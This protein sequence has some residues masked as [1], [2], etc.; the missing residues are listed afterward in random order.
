M[1][2]GWQDF[3]FSGATYGGPGLMKATDFEYRHQILI[4]LVVVTIAF[5]T[6]L[7]DRVDIVWSF[8]LGRPHAQ[9]LERML[10][11]LA[12]A[13]IGISAFIRTWALANPENST[14]GHGSA[15]RRDGLY[16][17]IRYPAQVGN[18]LFSLGLAFFAP[19]SRFVILVIVEAI[20]TFRLIR[21]EQELRSAVNDSP[22]DSKS[23]EALQ[24]HRPTPG[25][26]LWSKAIREES[27]KWGLL[28]TMIVFIYL[29]Q[30]E[31]PKF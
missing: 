31:S 18:F 17:F 5:L 19:V 11:S 25:F 21:R 28:L 10:F 12:A 26:G 3:V 4:H 27:A 1:H 2:A 23:T 14:L 9:L 15:V 29:L 8:V 30:I 6:Y 24:S 13:F 7:I 22:A 16:R 20:R